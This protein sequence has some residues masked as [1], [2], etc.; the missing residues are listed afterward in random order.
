MFGYDW[1]AFWDSTRIEKELR[2]FTFKGP[3]WYFT[4][5]DTVLIMPAMGGERFNIFCWNTQARGSMEA[6]NPVEMV[7]W[8]AQAPVHQDER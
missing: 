5:T 8:I 3:G 2:G 7:N 1:R 6:G 4:K